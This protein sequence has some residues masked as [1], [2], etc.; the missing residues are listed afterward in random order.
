MEEHILEMIN[1]HL[2][3]LENAFRRDIEEIKTDLK[4]MKET[5]IKLAE[6]ITKLGS[7]EDKYNIQLTI[8]K[9][10]RKEVERIKNEVNEID[11]RLIPIENSFEDLRAI[12][13]KLIAGVLLAL[14]SGLSTLVINIIKWSNK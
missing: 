9:E 4:D 14:L 10:S 1:S 13:R 7:V 12:K 11:K 3:R 6:V 8:C 5:Q 2:I